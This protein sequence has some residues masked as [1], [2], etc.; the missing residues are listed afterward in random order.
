MNKRSLAFFLSFLGRQHAQLPSDP[1]LFFET[2][3]EGPCPPDPEFFD[4]FP[5]FQSWRERPKEWWVKGVDE[6]SRLE[7]R[8]FHFVAWDDERFPGSLRAMRDPP[9]LLTVLGDA[10][11]LTTPSI[12]VVGAREPLDL[13]LQWMEEHL[14]AFLSC[15]PMTVVSGGARGIDQAAHRIALRHR[16]PTLVFLPSGLSQFYPSDLKD[17]LLPVCE[18]GGAFVSEFHPRTPMRKW[19]FQ[20]RN[21][22]IASISALTLVVEGR[23]RSGTWTTAKYVAEEGR[24][25]GCVPGPPWESSFSGN[26]ALLKDGAMMIRDA[27]DLV[28]FLSHESRRDS[29]NSLAIGRSNSLIH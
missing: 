1:A 20:I 22:L 29:G 28:M 15:L 5:E 23:I 26:L 4:R 27:Q 8:G 2:M 17:W 12:S 10:Q 19:N 7:E 25:L 3:K 13:S 24:Q 9:W 18:S 16:R 14:G 6:L 11:A 21:R